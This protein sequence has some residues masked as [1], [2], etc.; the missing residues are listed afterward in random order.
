MHNMSTPLPYTLYQVSRKPWPVPQHRK[1]MRPTQ[2]N[3]TPRPAKLPETTIPSFS[4]LPSKNA[5]GLRFNAPLTASRAQFPPPPPPPP[6]PLRPPSTVSTASGRRRLRRRL[7][8][9]PFT[10]DPRGGDT[11]TP[12]PTP[13]PAA[14]RRAARRDEGGDADGFAGRRRPCRGR[15]RVCINPGLVSVRCMPT[16]SELSTACVWR[17][18]RRPGGKE[19][20]GEGKGNDRQAGPRRSKRFG[21]SKPSRGVFIRWVLFS[22]AEPSFAAY[23]VRCALF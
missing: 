3:L 19:G 10:S 11:P 14:R 15:G 16:G 21:S 7:V 4:T 8:R 5:S 18:R 12:T 9:P 2:P 22:T 20:N 13:A 23:V 1:L 6:P 17:P